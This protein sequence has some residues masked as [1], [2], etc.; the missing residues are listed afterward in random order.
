MLD[1]I[2][3][4]LLF[5]PI[6]NLRGMEPGDVCA[7][8]GFPE[9]HV[10]IKS[11]QKVIRKSHELDRFSQAQITNLALDTLLLRKLLLFR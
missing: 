5:R 9:P 7:S 1:L 10:P 2:M 11:P 6:R 4:I 8:L 3:G